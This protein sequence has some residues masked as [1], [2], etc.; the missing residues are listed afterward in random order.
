MSADERGRPEQTWC[1]S[2]DPNLPESVVLGV[3]DHAR[4]GVTYLAEPIP[5]AEALAMVPEGVPPSRILRF[6]AHCTS[7][8][9]NNSGGACSLI[10]RLQAVPVRES[11]EGAVPRCHLR[12]VCQWWTQRGV[13]ACRRCPAVSTINPEGD[14]FGALVA[15]PSTTREQLAEWIAKDPTASVSIS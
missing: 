4:S 2:G 9:P 1:P 6:A 10:E 12:P 14:E 3:Q 11:E 13:D 15:D 7:R 5:A 8:C